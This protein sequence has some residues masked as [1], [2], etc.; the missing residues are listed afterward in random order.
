MS[1]MR[2]FAAL[3]L[4]LAMLLAMSGCGEVERFTRQGVAMDA[5]VELTAY[6]TDCSSALD[7]AERVIVALES[8]L[9]PELPGSTLYSINHSVSGGVSVVGQAAEI[10]ETAETVYSMSSGALDI[11]VYPLVKAWGMT[12]AQY[13]VPSDN[14]IASIRQSLG[15]DKVGVS[16]MSDTDS[17]LVTVP[18]GTELTFA[19]LARGCAAKYAAQAMAAEGAESG[20]VSIGSSI[21]TLGLRPDGTNWLVAIQDPENTSEN[22]AIISVGQTAVATTGGYQRYFTGSEGEIYSHI[23][24]PDTGRPVDSDLLSATA[25]AADGTYAD[26]LSTALYVLGENAARRLYQ[27]SDDFEMVLITDDGRLIVSGGLADGFEP[28][29][30]RTVEFVR[31]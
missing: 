12:N 2:R 25:V 29:G 21:Q 17:V 22:A 30:D 9:D 7:A 24:D 31:R 6:G 15:F 13:R 19:A 4:A 16:R 28:S 1:H 8:A 20:L 27:N 26:A 11:T 3:A 14:E 18:A 10:L 23:F 5:A